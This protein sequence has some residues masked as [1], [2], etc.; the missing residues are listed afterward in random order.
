MVRTFDPSLV[1]LTV[2]GVPI[3]GYADGTGVKV[4]RS[5]DSFSMV[6]GMDGV[7]S[8]AKSTNKS[9]EVTITLAQTSPSNAFLSALCAL[10]EAQNKGVVPV[11]I[12]DLSGTSVYASGTGWIKKPA[13]AEFGKEVSNR[14]W[15]VS[16][17]DL[18][19]HSGGNFSSI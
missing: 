1:I 18:K 16:C 15:V 6:T 10:D 4:S 9:G 14:E 3:G 11:M 19:M 12:S 7:T 8:R 17:A 2:K 5:E 13:D